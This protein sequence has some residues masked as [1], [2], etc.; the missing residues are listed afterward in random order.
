[1][2]TVANGLLADVSVGRNPEPSSDG[3]GSDRPGLQR[4]AR[5]VAVL[6]LR[7]ASRAPRPGPGYHASS[8]L[9]ALPQP[10]NDGV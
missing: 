7:G 9:E 8:G 4:L 2:K 10:H 3:A 1:M 5:D 6:A